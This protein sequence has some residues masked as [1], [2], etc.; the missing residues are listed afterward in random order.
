[1]GIQLLELQI[2]PQ[3][4]VRN[5][6]EARGCFLQGVKREDIVWVALIGAAQRKTDALGFAVQ[7]RWTDDF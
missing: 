4:K 3:V 5:Y 2:V 1:M 6:D 7:Y